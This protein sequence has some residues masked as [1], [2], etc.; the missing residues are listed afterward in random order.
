MGGEGPRGSSTW[1]SVTPPLWH[2]PG[3][4]TPAWKAAIGLAE[5]RGPVAQSSSTDSPT[6]H[7]AVRRQHQPRRCPRPAPTPTRRV[8]LSSQRRRGDWWRPPSRSG[9]RRQPQSQVCCR[10][11]RLRRR[12]EQRESVVAAYPPRSASPLPAAPSG[13]FAT[14]AGTTPGT[15]LT[16]TDHHNPQPL[17]QPR[18]TRPHHLSAAVRVSCCGGGS[19]RR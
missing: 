14:C 17:K 5:A 10:Q 8:L 11:R 15:K 12:G 18:K 4:G 16:S 1:P 7:G 3:E 19:N 9:P 6:G 2:P 13:G